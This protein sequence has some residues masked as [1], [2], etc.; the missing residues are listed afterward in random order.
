MSLISKKYR[1]DNE[2][3]K[4]NKQ[5]VESLLTEQVILDNKNIGN[6]ELKEKFP[7]HHNADSIMGLKKAIN[8]FKK[9]NKR[10]YDM[11][12]KLSNVKN[13]VF[14]K[15]DKDKLEIKFSVSSDDGKIL[16]S[17]VRSIYDARKSFLDHFFAAD[18]FALRAMH[19]GQLDAVQKLMVKLQSN[20]NYSEN[21][22]IFRFIDTTENNEDKTF[23]RAV[24]GTKYKTLYNNAAIFYLSIAAISKMK[25][26]YTLDWMN[27]TDST[28]AISYMQQGK[29]KLTD[30][31][32]LSTGILVE[33]SE[34]GTGAAKFTVQFK[35]SNKEGKTTRFI[36]YDEQILSINHGYSFDKI[37][38]SLN[39][40]A[41]FSNIQ[42]DIIN[43]V[44]KVK[45]SHSLN[46][47]QLSMLVADISH[48]RGNVSKEVKENLL[49][50][51]NTYEQTKK[52]FNILE[53]FS[54]FEDVISND[55]TRLVVEGK[56]YK[57]IRSL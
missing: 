12:V 46:T 18:Q 19:N 32:Y 13:L 51:V 4:T 40:L 25:G 48:L 33:N 43:T 26:N 57:W 9:V 54:R 2:K 56:F 23:L 21:S 7:I 35:I 27:V 31:L 3:E 39:K 29:I 38:A 49:K 5:E 41:Q 1:Y 34:L 44:K 8:T 11:T 10:K 52:A 16:V 6:S 14:V 22:G 42:K 15:F 47:E 30:G 24:I 17:E 36:N 28:I 20:Q 55:K 53:L 50:E 45:W 37:R